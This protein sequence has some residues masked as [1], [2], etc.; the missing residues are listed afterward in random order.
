VGRTSE[1][2]AKLQAALC[3]LMWQNSYGRVTIDAI[4]ER[5]GVKKGSFYHAYPDKAS[6]A[7]EAFEY[8]W[9]THSRPWMDAAFSSS[10]CPLDRISTWL[11]GGLE[12][13]IECQRVHGR[14]HGCPLFNVGS[15][16]STLEPAVAGKVTEILRRYRRYLTTTLRDAIAE[17][18]LELDDADEVARDVLTLVEGALTQARIS[19]SVDPIRRL[20]VSVGRLIGTTLSSS[21]T[22]TV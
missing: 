2:P 4:C 16:I 13:T 3:D 22:L 6:L 17:N 5:A 20:P 21:S 18:L 1:T 11:A 12:K 15:E 7:L 10:E 8:F 19:N 14:V 9:E